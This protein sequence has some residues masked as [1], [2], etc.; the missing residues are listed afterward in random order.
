MQ[1]EILIIRFFVDV[2]DLLWVGNFVIIHWE[3]EWQF[4]YLCLF[5][6][7]IARYLLAKVPCK[8]IFFIISIHFQELLSVK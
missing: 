8:R 6:C 5:S 4:I 3:Q 2:S 7:V 1:G